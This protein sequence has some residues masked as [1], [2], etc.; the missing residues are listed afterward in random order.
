MAIAQ[1]ISKRVAIVKQSGLGVPGSA[2]SQYRRRTSSVW[3][4]PTDTFENNEILSHQQSTGVTYGLKKATGKVDGLLSASTYALE[5]AALLRKGFTAG[6]STTAASV[7]IAGAGPT[8]TVT[9]AAGSFLTDGFKA[10]D[11]IRL[12]VG[13]LNAANIN[14][15]LL[16]IGLTALV[17]TV[18]P[19]NGVAL[20][21]E[22]PISGTTIS[23]FGKKSIA[24]LTGHTNDYFSVEESYA[25]LG[26]YELFTD[27]QVSQC[28]LSLPATGNA[29]ASFDW[30]ALAR[31]TNAA[32]AL[33]APTAETTTSALT[34][35]NGAVILNG[36]SVTNITG[37]SLT[38]NGNVSALDAVLGANT[39]PD[40]QRGRITVS[41]SFT[42]LFDG[43]TVQNLYTGQTPVALVLV[44]TDNQTGT[45]DF[46]TFSMSKIKITGDAP[47]DGEKAVVRTYPFTAEINTAGG[48]ALASDQTILSIQDSAA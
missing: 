34:A 21:A 48:A 42:A 29:T 3:Q 22:G 16:V 8:Y 27:C 6:V 28:A 13:T 9:R 37:A 19:V 38:I 24:P 4:A 7:T 46:V 33:T 35:V 2:G 1:G 10:G 14:K 43:V 44:I 47:D 12:S 17:A 26:R 31:A 30:V 18:K 25:D 39:S 40:V 41:G 15:N 36:A 20:V 11:V 32:A 5:F 23:V 45:S